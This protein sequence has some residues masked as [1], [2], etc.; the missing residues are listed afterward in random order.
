MVGVTVELYGG[1]P[2]LCPD[3]TVLMVL[4]PALHCP[5]LCG[6]VVRQGWVSRGQGQCFW[7]NKGLGGSGGG[8]G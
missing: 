8:V 2:C 1:R 5:L 7:S 3:V 6:R 4:C